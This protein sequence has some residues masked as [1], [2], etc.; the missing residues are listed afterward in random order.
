MESMDYIDPV[1]NEDVLSSMKDSS[2]HIVHIKGQ[3]NLKKKKSTSNIL[4]R[5]R[6]IEEPIGVVERERGRG[7]GQG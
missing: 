2:R 4:L 3:N 7:C 1:G 6:T 5:Q